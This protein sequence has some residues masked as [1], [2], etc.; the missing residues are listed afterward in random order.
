MPAAAADVS[1]SS[2]DPPGQIS[3]FGM[4]GVCATTYDPNTD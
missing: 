4:D 1:T 3:P 2:D